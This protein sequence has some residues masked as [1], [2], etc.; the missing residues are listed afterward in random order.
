MSIIFASSTPA[1]FWSLM[2][3]RRYFLDLDYKMFIKSM[4]SCVQCITHPY[5]LDFQIREQWKTKTSFCS[6]RR[7]IFF[8]H[9]IYLWDQR[10]EGRLKSKHSSVIFLLYILLKSGKC[11]NLPG[12]TKISTVWYATTIS[13]S[14]CRYVTSRII[15]FSHLATRHSPPPRQ[16][17]SLPLVPAKTNSRPQRWCC[18][19]IINSD[20]CCRIRSAISTNYLRKKVFAPPLDATSPPPSMQMRHQ[21][22]RRLD[23]A[24]RSVASTNCLVDATRPPLPRQP[25]YCRHRPA[26]GRRRAR[27]WYA[28]PSLRISSYVELTVV[29]PLM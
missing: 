18:P 9:Q 11:P 22:P 15:I 19:C 10:Q 21:R 3:D 12:R 17:F 26:T 13:S 5:L 29:A 2:Y 14:P 16:L 6:T 20:T 4:Q 1:A 27:N 7:N 28:T 8:T 25:I 23:T 24:R